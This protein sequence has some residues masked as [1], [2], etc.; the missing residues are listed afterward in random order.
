MKVLP[1][2]TACLLCLL[3]IVPATASTPVVGVLELDVGEGIAAEQAKPLTHLLQEELHATGHFTLV[4]RD[5]LED[6]LEEIGLQMAGCTTTECAVETG[7]MLGAQ[8]MVAGSVSRFGDLYVVSV[9]L[10]DVES[11]VVLRAESVKCRSSV[12]DFAI[13]G[14]HDAALALAAISPAARS[15]EPMTEQAVTQ[16]QRV[17]NLLTRADKKRLSGHVA[18][19]PGENALSLYQQVLVLDPDNPEAKRRLSEI[20]RTHEQQGF[21]AEQGAR[22]KEAA[23]FY[24]IA[25]RTGFAQTAL[26]SRL[27]R[28]YSR[29]AEN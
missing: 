13:K 3:I 20:A 7:R 29:L 17:L 1:V 6:I 16:H 19:P 9:R 12:D 4:E 24:E 5:K 22:W 26:E 23:R 2:L 10:I 21:E 18:D 27:T 15:S 14:M 11:A 25:V 28:A 8:Q